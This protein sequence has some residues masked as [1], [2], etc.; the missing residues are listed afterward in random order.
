[1]GIC[2]TSDCMQRICMSAIN[3]SLSAML[4]MQ[5]LERLG[6]GWMGVIME[7]EGVLVADTADLHSRAW[8]QLAQ[9]EGKPTPL[10]WAMKKAEGMKPEQVIL[11][12]HLAGV[13]WRGSGNFGTIPAYIV[14]EQE[15]IL[16]QHIPLLRVWHINLH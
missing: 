9:E 13:T 10:H 12:S 5:R 4:C 15:C 6:T 2:E 16:V 14:D 7:Y 3:L 11:L 1:M 8:Q